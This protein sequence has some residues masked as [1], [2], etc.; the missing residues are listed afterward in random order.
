M[1]TVG[2]S[3]TRKDI[4]R[5]LEIPEDKQG[6]DWLKGCHRHGDDY[7]IFCNV[8]VPGRTGHDYENVWEGEKLIWHA[9]NGSHF[10][11]TTI[12]NLISDAFRILSQRGSGSV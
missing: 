6:G 11:Q 12:Q 1:Y 4:Y 3:Y 10:D 7:Y 8:G 9:Q 2:A 5:I